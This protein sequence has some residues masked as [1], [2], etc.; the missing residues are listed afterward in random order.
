MREARLHLFEGYGIELEYMIVDMLVHF[1][2][3]DAKTA[4]I[5]SFMRFP[6]RMNPK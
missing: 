2:E 5:K 6:D 1:G 3:E 4:L